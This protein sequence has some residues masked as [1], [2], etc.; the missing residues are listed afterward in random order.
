MYIFILLIHVIAAVCELGSTFALPAL[1]N[2]QRLSLQQN[3]QYLFLEGSSITLLVTGL[4]MGALNT[5]LFTQV[6]YIA[7]II[8]YIGIQPIVAVIMPKRIKQQIEILENH[9]GDDLP[10]SYI[11]I[12]KQ[13]R[14]L[15]G[16]TH[17]AAVILIIF[18]VLKPF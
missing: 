15:N 9:E 4:I 6:W 7:S 13:M 5:Y 2:P 3:S 8:I 10:E 16:I 14:P 11:A 18:M 1:M 12:G 17:A